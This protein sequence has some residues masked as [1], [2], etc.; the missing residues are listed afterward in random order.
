M[1]GYLFLRQSFLKLRLPLNLWKSSC[2]SLYVLGLQG[3]TIFL[4]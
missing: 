1:G 2:L 3:Y 4:S